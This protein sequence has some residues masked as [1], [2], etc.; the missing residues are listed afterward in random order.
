MTV[1]EYLKIVEEQIR[2]KAIAPELIDELRQHIETQAEAYEEDG[3]TE[4]AALLKAVEDMGDPVDT[5]VQL[6]IVHQPK[7]DKRLF[8]LIAA[9]FLFSAV[10]VFVKQENA[11]DSGNIIWFGLTLCCFLSSTFR[12][13]TNDYDKHPFQMWCT[14]LTITI[15]V[16]LLAFD[17][18]TLQSLLNSSLMGYAA[19]CYY[20]RNGGR[21]EYFKLLSCCCIT[22]M[23]S[24]TVRSFSYT[25]MIL[26]AHIFIITLSTCRNWYKIPKKKYL[27]ILWSVPVLL[28]PA[29]LT[30]IS[31]NGYQQNLSTGVNSYLSILKASDNIGALL[32]TALCFLQIALFFCMYIDIR[33]LTNQLCRIICTGILIAFLVSY[34]QSFISLFGYAPANQVYFPFFSL[35]GNTVDVALY[36]Y[37]LLSATFLQLQRQDKVIPRKRDAK[38]PDTT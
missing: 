3:M 7:M 36:F 11:N 14:L 10:M 12:K 25:Y 9:G 8:L 16:F 19:I 34:L 22:C 33:K 20:Y 13:Y 27:T 26:T 4:D 15:A 23:M 28:I 6:D 38:K 31:L 17:T 5:G 32:F 1:S 24:L 21:K 2:Q 35:T 18:K 37:V 30:S 29:L